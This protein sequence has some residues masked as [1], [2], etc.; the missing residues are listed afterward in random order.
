EGVRFPGPPPTDPGVRHYRTGLLPRVMTRR[1]NA[2][3]VPRRA[4]VTGFPG[5]VSGPCGAR[6]GSPPPALAHQD[7]CSGASSILWGCPTPC[8]R[9]SRA[10]PVGSPCGPDHTTPGQMQGLPGSAHSV[11]VHARGLRPR[12]VHVRLAMTAY[13][14]LPS[15]CSERVGTQDW[16]I[17]GLHPL[18][19]P[20]PVN[21][22]PAPLPTPAHDSGPVWLAQPSLSG[23]STLHHYAGLSRRRP[24]TQVSPPPENG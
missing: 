17:S 23:T 9:P 5:A 12:Q 11:S 16:P 24:E 2:P 14:L 18:P 22:S 7:H 20:S 1:C 19:A 8:T 10:Y 13:P 4:P 15:A 3:T 21:A 6:P